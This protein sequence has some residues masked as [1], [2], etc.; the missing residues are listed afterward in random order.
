MAEIREF[1]DMYAGPIF[2]DRNRKLKH[3]Q[4]AAENQVLSRETATGY[5]YNYNSSDGG[6]FVFYGIARSACDATASDTNIDAVVNAHMANGL[7][8]VFEN[9]S[10]TWESIQ[11]VARDAGINLVRFAKREYLSG[12][13]SE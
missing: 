1:S 7:K 13:D 3:G 10:D 6:G 4:V 2:T 8:L 5:I 11:E 12:E 9:A